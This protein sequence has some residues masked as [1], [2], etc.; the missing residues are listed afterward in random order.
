MTQKTLVVKLPPEAQ[1]ALESRL[2]E[3]DFEWRRV[4]HARFSVKGEGGVAT[5]Y[6][7]GKLV[8]QSTDPELFLA[9]WTDLDLSQFATQI[10]EIDA[11]EA[12]ESAAPEEQD[13]VARV[14]VPTV[15]SDETGKGDY[16]GPLVVA[17]VRLDPEQVAQVRDW[18]VVDSKRLTDERALRLGAML[19]S[20]T[21]CA[22]ERLDP[23]QYNRD[24]DRQ[25]G[26]LNDLLAEL[27][28]RAIR[29]VA[30][31]GD[32]VLVDQFA[33]QAV[34]QKALEG[35]DLRLTQATRAERNPA[36]AAASVLARSEFLVALS[37]LS[38]EWGVD[39]R[40]GAGSPTDRA[41]LKFVQEHGI[42]ALSKVAK[43]HFK[44]TAKIRARL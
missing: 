18:G 40:K 41:G 38:S 7:S 19:R 12:S 36:V 4:P 21:T 26:G 14:D 31:T 2:R 10:S 42:D 3:G 30:Q 39:L 32:R 28:A 5:L 35:T 16:F 15:G 24:Y 34:M 13:E 27:H 9:R 11:P 25:E 17:A 37:E 33:N 44:N 1:D 6:G 23:Q 8:V 22:V 29:A 20:E 43:L